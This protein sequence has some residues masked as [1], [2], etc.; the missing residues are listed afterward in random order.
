MQVFDY[1]QSNFTI[2]IHKKKI[3]QNIVGFLKYTEK[4]RFQNVKKPDSNKRAKASSKT[5]EIVM[6][7]KGEAEEWQLGEEDV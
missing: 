1:R 4:Q 2:L 7:R 6:L 3:T 5:R